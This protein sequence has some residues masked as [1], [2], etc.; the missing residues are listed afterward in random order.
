MGY[1]I[2]KKKKKMVV[3]SARVTTD[4]GGVWAVHRKFAVGPLKFDKTLPVGASLK[5]D[6]IIVL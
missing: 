6:N 3:N 1:L 2:I 4:N 5:K